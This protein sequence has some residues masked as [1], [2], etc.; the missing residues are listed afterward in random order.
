MYIYIYVYIC[1]YVIL[2][3]IYCIPANSLVVFLS[4]SG[5]KRAQEPK[6]IKNMATKHAHT[7]KERM[8]KPPLT[9]RSPLDIVWINDHDLAATS[10]G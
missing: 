3:I 4:V 10:L 5:A 9:L 1:W 7:V 8:K 6:M 2:Y